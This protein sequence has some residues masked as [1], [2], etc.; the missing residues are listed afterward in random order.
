M[1]DTAAL[2]GREGLFISIIVTN[3][4]VFFPPR[5]FERGELS[6]SSISTYS[7]GDQIKILERQGG[8]ES[9]SEQE[10]DY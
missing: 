8:G 10:R 1:Q 9:E 6:L 4:H 7:N 3:Q 5:R 2:Y